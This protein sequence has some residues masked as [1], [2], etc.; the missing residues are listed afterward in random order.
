M[1]IEFFDYITIDIYILN[2]YEE[3]ILADENI[4]Q[5]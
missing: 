1:Y 5:S 3:E 4:L 2:D